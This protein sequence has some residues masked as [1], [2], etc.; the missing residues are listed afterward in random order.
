MIDGIAM[1]VEGEA[2]TTA[3]IKAVQAQL[4]LSKEEAT[5]LLIQ[6]RLQ[7]SVM[8]DIKI[9]EESIDSKIAQ[10]A[11]QNNLTIP[12]M[13]KI[14]LK[15]GTPWVKYRKSIKESLKKSKFFQKEVV[16]SIPN[17]SESELQLFYNNNKELFTIPK[18]IILQ[19]YSS[20]SKNKIE[21]FLKTK[22][23]KSIRSHRVTK[24]TKNMEPALLA[25]L[26]QTQKGNYTRPINTGNKYIVFKI[27]SKRGKSIMPFE[28][29]KSA[30]AAKWKEQQQQKAL[31]D[32][33][34]K[35]RTRADIQ[36]IR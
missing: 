22:K 2:I 11:E 21:E 31:K 8:K 29:A 7:K 15:Q 26:L 10:I 1:I 35:L 14:L 25:T 5:N 28:S 13:Q 9:S 17:P 20:S 27:I 12:K 3:E 36:K 33:F 19:E 6:D 34:E 4:D 18:Y 16:A 24:Y 23:T 30:V 32:Y